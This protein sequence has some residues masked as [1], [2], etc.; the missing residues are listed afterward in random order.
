M[1]KSLEIVKFAADVV[2]FH[3]GME[4]AKAMQRV[5]LPTKYPEIFGCV[6]EKVDQLVLQAF[7]T[8][9]CTT[10]CN[11]K[12]GMAS[13]I[14]LDVFSFVEEILRKPVFNLPENGLGRAWKFANKDGTTA[15]Q[16]VGANADSVYL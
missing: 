6:S 4:V 10:P 1:A 14:T 8:P 7:E 15:Q 9:K 12:Y 13:K 16:F 3:T 5:Q 11:E 2:H